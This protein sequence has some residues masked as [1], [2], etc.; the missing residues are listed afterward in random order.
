MCQRLL[1]EQVKLIRVFLSSNLVGQPKLEKP[2]CA[3]IYRLLRFEAKYYFLLCGHKRKVKSIFVQVIYIYMF[4]GGPQEE[5]NYSEYTFS[6]QWDKARRKKLLQQ[7]MDY[8]K[9][10]FIYP[11]SNNGRQEPLLSWRLCTN[12]FCLHRTGFGDMCS[13]NLKVGTKLKVMRNAVNAC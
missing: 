11:G 7:R 5:T 12:S 3:I 8:T 6:Q 13:V 4:R 1:G 10:I 9:K 2:I